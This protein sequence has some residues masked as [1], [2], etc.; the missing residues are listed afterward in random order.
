MRF[1]L[2]S[3]RD[4]LSL[5]RLISSANSMSSA[6]FDSKSTFVS[7]TSTSVFDRTCSA[8]STLMSEGVCHCSLQS[9]MLRSSDIPDGDPE[10][11]VFGADLERDIDGDNPEG[12]DGVFG[13]DLERDGVF[14]LER[15]I[16]DG[17]DLGADFERFDVSSNCLSRR[18]F[19]LNDG[20]L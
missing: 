6:L 16:P 12:S 10:D 11:G 7:L 9:S 14:D 17:D 18:N 3:R 1:S 4:T 5:L 20:S 15:D 13:A 2:D 8:L 19:V